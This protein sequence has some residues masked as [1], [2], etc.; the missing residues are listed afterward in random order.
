VD[1]TTERI[2]I[3]VAGS[4]A[5]RP[6]GGYLARP[7]DG[8]PRPAVLV[9]MEIFGVNAHI[10][11]VTERVAREGYVALAPDYFHRTG[12]GVEYGYDEKGMAGGMKL[13]GALRADEMIAD[14]QAAIAGLRARKDVR[15]K[16]GA[17]GFCIGGHMTYLS[18]CET[19][20][21][22][23]AS[24]YG[25]G[26]AA[27]QGPGGAPSTLSRTAKLRGKLLC[28]FG[29]KDHLIPSGQVDAIRQA[30]ER[31][32]AK[33]EVVVYPGADHGFFCDQ[34]PTFQ[35]AAADDAWRRV[36]ALFASELA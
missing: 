36:K 14:A 8:T 33:H 11:D 9:F 23:A 19:D 29:E 32:R 17:M 18:A 27:A 10:R 20:I 2:Q 21:A 13:L 35:K 6:M 7:S 30:L 12:P 26:I 25:G 28:L 31:A 1:I 3:P 5:A 24:F 4:P 15:A 16:I 22:A 34:R